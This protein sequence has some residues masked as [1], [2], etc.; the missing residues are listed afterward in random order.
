MGD[1]GRSLDR[2][3]LPH[4]DDAGAVAGAPT[5]PRPVPAVTRPRPLTAAGLL[6]AAAL[7]VATVL[8]AGMAAVGTGRAGDP[9]GAGAARSAPA[10]TPSA[11]GTLRGLAPAGTLIGTAVD[12][13][14]LN[15][16]PA[17][18]GVLA[19][20]FN[21]VTAENAMK[22]RNL[23]PSPGVYAWAGGDQIVDLARRNGQAVYGHTLVWH[24]DVPDWVSPD[25]PAQRLREV[26][27]RHVT[28][29]VAHYRGRVWAW[30]VVNEVLAEDGSLRD[31][32][33][34]RKLGPGYVA[35]AFRWARQADPDARLFVNE[36]GTEGRTAKADAL[37]D[38]VRRLRADGVPVD[39]VGFQGHLDAERPP[40]D[41]RGNLRRFAALGVRVA[42]TELDVR[43]RLPATAE[44]LRRQAA[45]YREVLR[46][47]LDVAA[48]A[49][50]TVW[51]F[52]DARSWIPGYH[53]GFGAACLFDADFRPKPAHAALL[54]ELVA[55][56]R[57]GG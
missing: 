3:S 48:C 8:L 2:A 45:V 4:P 14:G 29:V 5:R 35:D 43:V 46:A 55:R 19:A 54:D 30:D 42:V 32:L 28:A 33:W 40:E 38:L 27:R 21:A 17:Y 26:L 11:A 9:G 51:G 10:Y 41:V 7:V 34:L 39:G 6:V 13:R 22:W 1:G 36:Y 15:L 23:E 18:P 53:V 20:E 52:T 47:C 25:W 16:D 57:T 12:P 24:N 56:R 44:G 37:L 31:T 50:V 49:S